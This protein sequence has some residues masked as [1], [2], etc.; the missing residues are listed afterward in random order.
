MTCRSREEADRAGIEFAVQFPGVF[1]GVGRR[2]NVV[3]YLG[4]GKDGRVEGSA[5]YA[6]RSR[7]AAHRRG[8]QGT[9]KGSTKTRVD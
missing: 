5:V 2:P 6:G 4:N 3:D 7:T 9:R 8:T 1:F